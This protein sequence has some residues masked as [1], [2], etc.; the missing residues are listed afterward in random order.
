MK[1]RWTFTCLLLLAAVCISVFYMGQTEEE[2]EPARQETYT[3]KQETTAVDEETDIVE[4]GTP[5][6]QNKQETEEG[7]GTDPDCEIVKAEALTEVEDW[8]VSEESFVIADEK[9]ADETPGLCGI[10]EGYIYFDYCIS[11]DEKDRM[12]LV[13]CMFNRKSGEIKKLYELEVRDIVFPAV[14]YDG[15]MYVLDVNMPGYQIWDISEGGAELFAEGESP[16]YPELQL[17][18]S[19]LMIHLYQ[20]TGSEVTCTLAWVDLDSKGSGLVRL[21][22]YR[23]NRDTGNVSGTEI[24]NVGGWGGGVIYETF[25]Y[26]EEPRN[27]Y[28]QKGRDYGEQELWYYDFATGKTT[29]QALTLGQHSYYVGGD[30]DCI[31]IDRAS[32]REPLSKSGTIYER[33]AT[34]YVSREIP[35]IDA[36]NSIVQTRKIANGQILADCREGFLLIDTEKRVC[37]G[38]KTYNYTYSDTEIAYVDEAGRVHVRKYAE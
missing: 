17:S 30:E 27:T 31:L 21:A 4:E 7:G 16:Y 33:T 36:V 12:T 18:G 23:E 8:A 14:F 10:S 6:K 29:K 11:D 38:E 1:T 34:G 25:S 37:T 20:E 28:D 24:S 19:R 9:Y 15:H 26:D 22:K 5:E 13:Y 3:Q 2:T 35:G 32:I